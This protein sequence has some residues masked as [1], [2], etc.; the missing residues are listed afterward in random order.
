MLTGFYERHQL[1]ALATTVLLSWRQDAAATVWTQERERLCCEAER[2]NNVALNRAAEVEVELLKAIGTK[3]KKI[4][5]EEGTRQGARPAAAQP[6]GPRQLAVGEK[7]P[8]AEPQRTVLGFPQG[9][10]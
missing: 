5:L 6:W 10:L 2:A 9:F 8:L 3:S 1:L 4:P 7:L